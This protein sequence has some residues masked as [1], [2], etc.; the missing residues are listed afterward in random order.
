MSAMT[1]RFLDG[2]GVAFA[3]VEVWHPPL[4]VKIVRSRKVI[5]QYKREWDHCQLCGRRRRVLHAHHIVGGARRSDE[6]TN[7]FVVCAYG[8][9]HD[10]V[11]H[12]AE[13][14]PVVEYMKWFTNREDLSW[15][16]LTVLYGKRLPEPVGDS[17]II[18]EYR[19]N[20][21]L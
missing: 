16:R 1:N 5:T 14:L 6:R 17:G 19:R 12:S 8:R 10:I 15:K 4:G 21:G 18:Q 2:L 3:D 11:Q 7:L 20:Q 13:W 9:C